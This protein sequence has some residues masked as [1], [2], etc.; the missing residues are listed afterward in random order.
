MTLETRTRDK[1][2]MLNGRTLKENYTWA[3]IL[4]FERVMFHAKD[5]HLIHCPYHSTISTLGPSV[6]QY[7]LPQQFL[8]RLII[9][10]CTLRFLSYAVAAGV[11]NFFR[12][13]FIGVFYLSICLF[14][15]C[16]FSSCCP[17]LNLKNILLF[18]TFFWCCNQ[19]YNRG[20]FLWCYFNPHPHP[21]IKYTWTAIF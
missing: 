7:Q 13:I 15:F 8:L 16:F 1:S 10:A 14:L 3:F 6:V 18:L 11:M 21:Q 17:F 20:H 12:S 4:P 9:V 5:Q 19:Y 2:W